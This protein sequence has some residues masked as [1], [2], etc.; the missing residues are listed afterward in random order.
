VLVAV[1]QSVAIAWRVA[2]SRVAIGGPAV[3]VHVGVDA[4]R[5]GCSE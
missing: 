3:Y 5:L 4:S 2:S 1:L